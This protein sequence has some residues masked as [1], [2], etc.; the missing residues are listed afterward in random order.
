MSPDLLI[1]LEKHCRFVPLLSIG[2]S[3]PA[4][5]RGFLKIENSFSG[6]IFNILSGKG[7]QTTFQADQAPCS[8]SEAGT[9]DLLRR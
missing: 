1:Q 4:A 9:V 6:A 8:L 7:G 2:P 5:R 3:S